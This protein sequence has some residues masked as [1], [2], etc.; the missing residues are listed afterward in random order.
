MKRNTNEESTN[1]IMA[2][3]KI[4][5]VVADVEE[6]EGFVDEMEEEPEDLEGDLELDEDALEEGDLEEFEAEAEEFGDEDLEGEEEEPI[7]FPV[8]RP[9]K[10]AGD[11]EDDIDEDIVD[12]D[13]V[14]ADLSVIL[15]DR[16][17]TPDDDDDDED[18]DPEPEDR[19]LDPADKIVA[20]RPGE[21]VCQSCFLVKHP[22]QRR[23]A[24]GAIDAKGK[25]CMDCV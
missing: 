2:K 14:E 21:F 24:K 15:K 1:R 5:E 18:A 20:K 13:D 16:L 23:N 4:V 6:V 10:E 3:K 22:S 19:T 7:E 25:F 11:D 8:A 12:P 9:A 17:A